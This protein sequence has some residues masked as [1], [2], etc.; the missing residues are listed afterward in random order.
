ML[1]NARRAGK[2]KRKIGRVKY[3][4]GYLSIQHFSSEE[5]E[6]HSMLIGSS[7][8]EQPP[9]LQVPPACL[10]GFE[11][12]LGLSGTLKNSIPKN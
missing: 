6:V 5:P 3:L 9:N 4:L 11:E 10:Q 12:A 2:A 8:R 1:R 7:F